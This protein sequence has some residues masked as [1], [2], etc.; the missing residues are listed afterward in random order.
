MRGGVTESEAAIIADLLEMENRAE[1][2]EQLLADH[3]KEGEPAGPWPCPTCR[4]ARIIQAPP[5][6]GGLPKYPVEIRLAELE[7]ILS[8]VTDAFD[9]EHESYVAVLG[10]RHP[11][12]CQTC[13]LLVESKEALGPRFWPVGPRK[14]G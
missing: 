6:D 1:S 11:E 8:R 7:D 5:G 10:R 14:E 13:N 9:S 12:T 2:A 4:G 3:A